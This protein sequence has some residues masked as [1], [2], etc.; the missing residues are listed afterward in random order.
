MISRGVPVLPA[1]V[2]LVLA[3]CSGDGGP[4]ATSTT[5]EA[6]TTTAMPASTT[7]TT[8]PPTT[9]PGPV[10]V[11]GVP[12]LCPPDPLPGSDGANGSGCPPPTGS[13]PDGIWFGK[14]LQATPAGVR[15]DPGCFF[16]GD[17]AV[18]AAAADGITDLPSPH[19]L[20]NPLPDS[21]EV[22]AAEDAVAYSIDNSGDDLAFITF[23]LDEWP[24]QSGGYT[25]CPGEGCA[26]WL[27]VNGG[28]ITEI[29][30]QYL[31]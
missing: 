18:A 13:L 30:E 25:L 8:V 12:G 23:S 17:A 28:V 5:S 4:F 31:P 7:T 26:V 19:Y 20:R 2:A 3:G 15:F 9:T 6:T 21:M 22:P 27:H 24:A 29:L 1:L 11:V 16:F 14:V 10:F